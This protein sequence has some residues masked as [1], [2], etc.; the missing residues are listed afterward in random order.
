[1]GET[2]EESATR[3]CCAGDAHIRREAIAE[4]NEPNTLGAGETGAHHP[5]ATRQVTRMSQEDTNSN[6]IKHMLMTTSG[7]GPDDFGWEMGMA[8]WAT[9]IGALKAGW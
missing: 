4:V 9:L 6:A 1:M 3:S 2:K 5:H 7:R 8:C